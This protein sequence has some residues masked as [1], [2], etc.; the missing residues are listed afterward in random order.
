MKPASESRVLVIF[1]RDFENAE[2]DPENAAREDIRCTAD[3]VAAVLA[4]AG[5]QV[6]SLG[7]GEDVLGAAREIAASAPD[8]VF[9]LCE[10][11]GGDNRFEPLLPLLLEHHGIAYTGSPP[12]TL[13]LALNKHKAKDVLRANGVP[14]PEAAVFLTP[15][16]VGAPPRRQGDLSSI[17]MPFPLIVKPAR[18]DA[19][20]GVSS[21]SV[22]HDRA[23]LERQVTYVIARYNQPALAER[24]IEG[25]EI[26]VSLLGRVDDV[27]QPDVLP[28][29]EIDFSEMP[30]DRPRIVSFEG[31]WVEGSPEFVGT[32]PIPC[33]PLSAD[34][35]ARILAVARTAFAAMELR[36]YARLDLRLDSNGVPYVIDVNPNCDLSPGAGF[37]RAARSA[38]LSYDELIRRIVDLALQR[39]SHA[40]TIP[41]SVRSRSARANHHGGRRVPDG[42]GVLRDRAGGRGAGSG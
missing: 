22:V 38:G 28:L 35:E 27:F 2:A 4:R 23:A 30:T 9:N 16:Q 8:V 24:Y 25:R 7:I 26:Y 14:T 34:S 36:D 37:A 21:A 6:E 15:D 42:R 12:V 20:V 3:E 40:D 11:L 32:K 29:H 1:N 41:L 5:F 10:S 13:G 18:E 33:L 39:R 19:S 31:K 17:G